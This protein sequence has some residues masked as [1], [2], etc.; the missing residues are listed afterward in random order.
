MAVVEPAIHLSLYLCSLPYQF[1]GLSHINIEHRT[2]SPI[3]ETGIVLEEWPGSIFKNCLSVIFFFFLQKWRKWADEFQT[4][5]LGI[6]T[7][8]TTVI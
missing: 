5:Q 2:I 6:T 3:F 1:T 7:H 8:P 4:F